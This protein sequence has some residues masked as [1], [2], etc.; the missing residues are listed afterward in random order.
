M[1]EIRVVIA[2]DEPLARRGLQQML[3]SHKDCRIVAECRNGREVVRVLAAGGVDVLFLD[4]QMPGMDGF[5]VLDVLRDRPMPVIVFVTAFDEF[6]IRAFDANALDYILKPLTQER[7]DIAMTRVRDR[8]HSDKAVE[9]AAKL[10]TFLGDSGLP[11]WERRSVVV[12]TES[13]EI[14]LDPKEIDWIEA[15]DYYAAVHALNR[16]HLIRESLSSFEQRLDPAQFIRV[17]RS[18]IVRLD[19]VRELRVTDNGTVLVLR[20]GTQVPVSRRRKERVAEAI[21]R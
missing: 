6:A 10:A 17:H 2:D 16:R 3:A 7:F 18:A 11:G 13:G 20:D 4:I 12:P 1:P 15:E 8:M 9:I 14:V 19:R 5:Q 21:R